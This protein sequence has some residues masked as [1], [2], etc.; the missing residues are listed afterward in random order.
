MVQSLM[1]WIN[2][3]SGNDPAG[4]IVRSG[5]A[6]DML[7]NAKTPEEHSASAKAISD[8]IRGLPKK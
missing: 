3:V 5:E 7:A 8:L 6:F 4:F 2:Q 1:T